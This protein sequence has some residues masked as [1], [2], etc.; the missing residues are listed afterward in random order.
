MEG[1]IWFPSKSEMQMKLSMINSD[2]NLEKFFHT[3]LINLFGDLG[4]VYEQFVDLFIQMLNELVLLDL[5]G[6]IMVKGN[7]NKY[8]EVLIAEKDLCYKALNLYKSRVS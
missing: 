5:Q 4:C 8:F 3:K 1:F 6:Y 2:E 7:V